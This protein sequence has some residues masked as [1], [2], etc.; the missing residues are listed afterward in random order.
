[1][2]T[3]L[4]GTWSG[5]TYT[6]KADTNTNTGLSTSLSST[7]SS[8]DDGTYT[9]R[10]N[11]NQSTGFT[12]SINPTLDASVD[13]SYSGDYIAYTASDDN[14]YKYINI[15]TTAGG[16]TINKYI[17]IN[18]KKAINNTKTVKD[19][20]LSLPELDSGTTTIVN[21]TEWFSYN[22]ISRLHINATVKYSD[23]S[24]KPPMKISPSAL[25]RDFL[26]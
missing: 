12:I 21:S 24:T 17:R 3:T 6:V 2:S 25:I 15:S 10:D 4:S 20:E 9:V 19:V 5:G 23:D 16:K 26:K 8:W 1:M 14:N 18:P 13:T 22:Y 7:Y 11:N